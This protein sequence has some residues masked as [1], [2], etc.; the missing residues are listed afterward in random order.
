MKKFSHPLIFHS[1]KF[2]LIWLSSTEWKAGP[3]GCVLECL[4]VLRP[5]GNHG[6]KG[7]GACRYVGQGTYYRLGVS[8]CV[9]NSSITHIGPLCFRSL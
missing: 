7:T 1:F 9:I 3:A 8:R 2:A 5:V 6:D 4:V